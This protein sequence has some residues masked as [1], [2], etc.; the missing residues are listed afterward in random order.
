MIHLPQNLGNFK[1]ECPEAREKLAFAA[2]KRWLE[3]FG[4]TLGSDFEL[5]PFTLLVRTSC[6]G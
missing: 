3:L 1:Y 6:L 4:L 2:Q 5:D